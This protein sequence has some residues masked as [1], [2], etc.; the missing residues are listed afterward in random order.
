MGGGESKRYFTL[1][2]DFLHRE[3][4][5]MNPLKLSWVKA[6]PERKKTLASVL[7]LRHVNKR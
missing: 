5:K 2:E 6:R 4:E 1:T 7:L 3:R